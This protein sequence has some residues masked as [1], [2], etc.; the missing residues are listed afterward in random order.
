METAATSSASLTCCV[1]RSSSTASSSFVGSRPS[2]WPIRSRTARSFRRRSPRWIGRRMRSPW[3]RMAREHAWRI[4]QV[5]YVENLQ[6][7]RQSNFSTARVSPIVPSWIRSGE[8]QALPLERLRHRD[9]EPEVRLDHQAL[10]HGVAP[11]HA[12][13]ERRPPRRDAAAGSAGARAGRAEANP[14]SRRSRPRRA[15]SPALAA[16][17]PL[18]SFSAGLSQ[19]PASGP[20]A[21]RRPPLVALRK[22][23]NRGAASAT[24]ALGAR[25]QRPWPHAAC[26]RTRRPIPENPVRRWRRE[27]LAARRAIRRRTP[28]S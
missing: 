3:L 22:A 9:D 14:G 25:E 24:V 12:L 15:R 1:V 21:N 27:E 7:R 4:H 20:A 8:R 18:A 16:D 13:G 2:S 28:P 5:A 10:R 19:L 23:R 17:S 11:L 26:S 6:P